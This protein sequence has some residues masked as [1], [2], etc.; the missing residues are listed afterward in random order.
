MRKLLCLSMVVMVLL[1]SACGD[2]ENSAIPSDTNNQSDASVGTESSTSD[3]EVLSDTQLKEQVIS[4][5]DDWHYADA[6][7]LIVSHN[8]RDDKLFDAFYSYASLVSLSPSFDEMDNYREEHSKVYDKFL[9]LMTD[10][11]ISVDEMMK[12]TESLSD[13]LKIKTNIVISKHSKDNGYFDPELGMT[14]ERLLESK[15]WGKPKDINRTT[16]KN[17]V[18]EQWVYY[19]DKYV[20][21][22][23]GIV[24]SIQE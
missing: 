7:E 16:T 11:I 15:S 17:G 12:F 14:A 22:E 24:T 23:D 20:Y 6:K 5:L 10:G 21:L 2:L 3:N 4:L 9:Q 8:K 19:G 13:E 1:L 18:R